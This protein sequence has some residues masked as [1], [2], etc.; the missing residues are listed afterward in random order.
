V[1]VYDY[2]STGSPLSA[3]GYSLPYNGGGCDTNQLIANAEAITG[4]SVTGFDGCYQATTFAY[5]Q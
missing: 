5:F 1:E 3:C 2:E 4:L